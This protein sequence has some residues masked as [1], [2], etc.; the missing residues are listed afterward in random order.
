VRHFAYGLLW[1]WHKC[2]QHCMG[3]L[4]PQ[5]HVNSPHLA[6]WR[7]WIRNL[8][9]LNNANRD[10][11]SKIPGFWVIPKKYIVIPKKYFFRHCRLPRCC[12]QLLVSVWQTWRKIPGSIASKQHTRNKLPCTAKKQTANGDKE[13]VSKVY[14]RGL[15]A[16]RQSVESVVFVFLP[17]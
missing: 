1:I 8:V 7:E 13:A 5:Q 14:L 17:K 11:L 15:Q 9:L 10:S 6:P 12:R 2:L 3:G 16:K 4:F